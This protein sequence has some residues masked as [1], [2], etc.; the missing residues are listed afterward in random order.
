MK[1]LRYARTFFVLVFLIITVSSLL[2]R[3]VLAATTYSAAV[4][5]GIYFDQQPNHRF[6]AADKERLL[7]RLRQ[8]TGWSQLRVNESNR[9]VV[10]RAQEFAAGSGWA[11]QVFAEVFRSGQRFLVENHARSLAVNFGQLDAGTTYD[12]PRAG[13]HL[14][15]YRVRLDLIDFQQ[16]Q[17][18]AELRAAF[19]EG[20]VLLH[21]LLHGL[22]FRDTSL[23][24]EVGACEQ[25]VNKVRA[26]L[27]LP[28][29]D[30]Y[31]GETVITT[32][33]FR[34]VRLRFKQL[35]AGRQAAHEK[36]QYLYFLMN[37]LPPATLDVSRTK[38][39]RMPISLA[40]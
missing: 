33:H 19:D 7:N 17:A 8:I 13:I 32:H 38:Q 4:T 34:I 14:T 12:D 15:I 37:A 5:P 36:K 26:E 31:L 16:M 22:G 35:L 10:E 27:G 20:F 30:H 3:G 24:A 1:T 40:D 23:P 9:L 11:R 29:R 18:S 25:I 6:L 2:E 39:G 21:E 28:L